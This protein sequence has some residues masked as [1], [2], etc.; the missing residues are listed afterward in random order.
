MNQYP[1]RLIEVDIPIKKLNAHARRHHPGGQ[2]EGHRVD[3]D[4]TKNVR[5]SIICQSK[6]TSLKMH[7]R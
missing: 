1:K 6:K 7:R 2:L 4:E 3:V 5:L